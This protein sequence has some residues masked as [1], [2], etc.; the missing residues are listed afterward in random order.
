MKKESKIFIILMALMS[1]II[2]MTGL[3]GSVLLRW[4][5]AAWMSSHIALRVDAVMDE[6]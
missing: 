2:F 4:I 3:L 6:D 5:V 1:A